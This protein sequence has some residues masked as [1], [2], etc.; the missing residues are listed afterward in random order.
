MIRRHSLAWLR[1]IPA[2]VPESAA[3]WQEAGN[4]FVVCRTRPG[5]ELSLG[6][7]LPGDTV[8]RI[9]VAAS[10]SDV[11]EFSRPPAA[12]EVA[13][14]LPPDISEKLSGIPGGCV[15]RLIG[16]RMWQAITGVCYVRPESDVDF[17]IDLGGVSDVATAASWVSSLESGA[18]VDAE[19]SLPGIGEI[20][21][22]EWGSE[23]LLVKSLGGIRVASISSLLHAG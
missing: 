12:R 23:S 11:S 1:E 3:A 17:V 6:F 4:P 22:N 13:A 8:R 2:G 5:E 14:H 21:A 19:L 20:H 7:C 15:V 18:R 16:S 9:P 10:R